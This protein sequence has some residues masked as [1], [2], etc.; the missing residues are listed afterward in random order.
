MCGA[1]EVGRE[2]LGRELRG[3]RGLGESS[4]GRTFRPPTTVAIGKKAAAK[5]HL[6]RTD[7]ATDSHE[8]VEETNGKELSGPVLFFEP[9]SSTSWRYIPFRGTAPFST[10]STKH[11]QK[12]NRTARFYL[13]P[14]PNATFRT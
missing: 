5:T 7:E 6:G 9:H 13:T 2:R 3:G 12:W 1:A 10:F 14:K 4:S 11:S 8:C